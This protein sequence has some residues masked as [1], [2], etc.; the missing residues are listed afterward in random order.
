MVA[1]ADHPP[2]GGRPVSL[3]DLTGATW[4]VPLTRAPL[5]DIWEQIFREGRLPAPRNTVETASTLLTVSLIERTDMVAL[6][7]QSVAR[8]FARFG[9]VTLPVE[10]AATLRPFGLVRRKNRV[11]TPAMETFARILTDLSLIHI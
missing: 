6:L 1:R 5:G 3:A 7:P 2:A 10:I 4:I 9:L 11:P 8:G